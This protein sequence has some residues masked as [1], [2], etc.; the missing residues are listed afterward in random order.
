MGKRVWTASG[1]AG[2]FVDFCAESKPCH[3]ST[4]V[5]LALSIVIL[6]PVLIAGSLERVESTEAGLEYDEIEKKL[7]RTILSDGLHQ[8]ATFGR[9]IKW[10]TTY[11]TIDY[12]GGNSLEC[13]SFDGVVVDCGIN[14]QFIV[15]TQKIYDLTME[16]KDFKN[17]R[18]VVIYRSRSAIRHACARFTA[19]QFQ[20]QRSAVSIAMNEEV[21]KYLSPIHARVIEVQ[22]VQVNRPQD[23]ENA[24]EEKEK[25]IAD[26]DLASN[27]RQQLLTT[28]TT[29]LLVARQEANKTLNDAVTY[30]NITSDRAQADADAMDERFD[31]LAALYS[32][33]KLSLN[34]S[35]EALLAYVGSN[36]VQSAQRLNVRLQSPAEMSWKADL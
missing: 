14:F 31:T 17:F 9:L 25:A 26:I 22:L 29:S 12:Q 1:V 33:M 19:R 23:Y 34:Y 36:V 6:V 21:T 10:P 8:K 4:C 28:V 13:N 3:I 30:S 32:D 27:E 15:E 24:V 7:S 11:Q 18:Q 20:T 35:T 2:D 5:L 16:Y